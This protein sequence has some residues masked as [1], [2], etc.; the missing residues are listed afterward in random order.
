MRRHARRIEAGSFWF[1]M[2]P[3]EHCAFSV[4]SQ[5]AICD[6]ISQEE[7]N[8]LNMRRKCE[9]HS[10]ALAKGSERQNAAGHIFGRIVGELGKLV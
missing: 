3:T 2:A 9:Q 6:D 4:D 8:K 10:D 7:K 5:L 1:Y